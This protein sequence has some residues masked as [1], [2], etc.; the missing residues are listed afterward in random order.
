[1]IDSI[2]WLRI[3]IS[4]H[5]SLE[6]IIIFFGTA[7][8]GEPVLFIFAFLAAQ[9]VISTFSFIILSFLGT[10]FSNTLWF[11]LGKTKTVDRIISHRYTNATIS[12]VNEAVCRVSQ[13]SHLVG[14][15]LAKFLFATPIT[16]TMYVHKTGLGFKTFIYYESIAVALSLL[17]YIPIGYVSGLGFNYFAEILQNLYGAIGFVVLMVIIIIMIQLWLERTFVKKI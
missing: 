1:M 12:V 7:F 11:F 10:F 9:K 2:E 13:G 16:L 15:I 6:Y 14:L 5:R 17:F 3:F 8:G 4:D